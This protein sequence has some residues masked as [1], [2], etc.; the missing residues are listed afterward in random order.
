MMGNCKMNGQITKQVRKQAGR[1]MQISPTA[2][3][4]LICITGFFF[5]FI[6]V[7]SE[8]G[9][10]FERLFFGSRGQFRDAG[11]SYMDLY[12]PIVYYSSPLPYGN[13]EELSARGIVVYPPLA[14]LTFRAIGKMLPS[15]FVLTTNGQ[16][17]L[18]TYSS[19]VLVLFY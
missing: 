13:A 9:A 6:A 7:F 2:L 1:L 8:E 16:G 19:T 10:T 4:L 5:T 18:A 17:R 11:D 3:F 12:N 14:A 15:D